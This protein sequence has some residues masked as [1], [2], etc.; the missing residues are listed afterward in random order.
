[1]IPILKGWDMSKKGN[2]TY[3]YA[4][5]QFIE[6]ILIIATLIPYAFRIAINISDLLI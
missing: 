5:T 4:P 3:I 6:L 1:M 2:D